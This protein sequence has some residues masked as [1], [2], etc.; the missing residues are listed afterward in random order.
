VIAHKVPRG[1]F[2]AHFDPH[3]LQRVDRSLRWPPFRSG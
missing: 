3:H 2:P 1:I